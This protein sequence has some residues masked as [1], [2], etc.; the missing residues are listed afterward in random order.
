MVDTIN[1]KFWLVENIETELWLVDTS[2]TGF[3]LV[4]TSDD[5]MLKVSGLTITDKSEHLEQ[6]KKVLKHVADIGRRIEEKHQV[7]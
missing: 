2:D 3:W 6:V 4:N 1:T 5:V 7:K